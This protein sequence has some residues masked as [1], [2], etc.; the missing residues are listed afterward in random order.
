MRHAFFTR[1]A[2]V[3]L[4]ALAMA[5]LGNPLGAQDQPGQPPAQDPFASLT[6]LPLP[7]RTAETI[8]G[9]AR[10]RTGAAVVGPIAKP[11]GRIGNRIANRIQ[12]RINSRIDKNYSPQVNTADSY[13]G[14]EARTRRAGADPDR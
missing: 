11:L 8:A 5:D 3:V 13:E 7:E 6:T 4:A 14:A 2:S 10:P 12:N 9:D 1:C